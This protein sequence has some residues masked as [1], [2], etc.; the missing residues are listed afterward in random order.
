MKVFSFDAEVDGLYGSSLAI[1]ATVRENGREVA[2][3]EARIP[4]L[5]VTDDWVQ[6][7]VLPALAGMPVTHSTPVEIE[8]AFWAFWMEHREDAVAIAHCGSPVESGLFRRCIEREL[9]ARQWNGPF[10]LHEVGTALLMSGEDPTSVDAYN[11]RHGITVPFDGVAH[12][13]MY[14]AAAAAV[15]WE[16]LTKK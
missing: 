8:E 3:F 16:H 5:A 7:N 1:A 9:G 6:G 4:D 2:R 10:P 13:P 12:H 15:A 11:K 14:D